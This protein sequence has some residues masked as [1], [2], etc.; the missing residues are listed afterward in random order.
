MLGKAHAQK[1]VL[2]DISLTLAQGECLGL[3]GASG[4]GKSTLT[5][6]L[7]GL[8]SPD[9]VT[10]P[11]MIT[12]A[13]DAVTPDHMP[14]AMRRRIQAVFQD[15]Y[16]AFNPRHSV[17]RII[18]EPLWLMPE[19]LTAN[20]ITDKVAKA[21]ESVGLDPDMMHRHIHAFSGG[22]RQRIAIARALITTPDVILFD[23]PTSSLDT[24]IRQQI[25]TLITDL[26]AER[27]LSVIFISHDLAVIR[28]ICHRVMVLEHGQCVEM[29]ETDAI[30]QN[31]QH[32]ATRALLDAIPDQ[33]RT[34]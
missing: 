26:V 18:A 33:I 4:A 22:Q 7:L 1:P 8:E 23:E 13:G 9:D 3:V 20:A 2:R 21:L 15:P 6:L 28:A 29:G 11:A 24:L 34:G 10:D 12:L 27:N 32:A 19:R 30:F 17:R 14:P 16:S 5:R 25:L 31:P